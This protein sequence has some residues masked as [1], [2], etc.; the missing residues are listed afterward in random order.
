MIGETISHYRILSELGAGGMGIVYKAEDLKLRRPVALK[1]LPPEL[2]R[3]PEAKQRLVLE[4]QAASALDHPNVCTIHEIDETADG[5]L[6]MVMACY[7]GETLKQ[8]LIRGLLPADTAVQIATQVAD[9]LARA[10]AHSI[11][12]RDIKPANVFLDAYGQV[13]ILDFGLAML[14]GQTRLTRTGTTMGT[15][16]YMSPEQAR[17]EQADARSDV[18]AVGAVLHEM[19]TG[20]APFAGDHQQTVIFS[21]LN[22][23]P[24][25]V[26][27][28]R[29]DVPPALAAIVSGCLQKDPTK[30]YQNGGELL[31]ALRGLATTRSSLSFGPAGRRRSRRA[32]RIWLGLAGLTV[33]LITAFFVLRPRLV[34]PADEAIDSLAVLPLDNLSGD[35]AQEYFADGMTEA[36]IAELARIGALRVI[37][38]TSVMRFKDTDLPLPSIAA[39]LDVDAIVEGSVLR[40]GNRVRITAQLIRA[41]D[42]RHLWAESYER[43]LEDIL[44][45][46]QQIARLIA[47]AVDV[48]LTPG[49]EAALSA[50]VTVDPAAHEAYLKGRQLWN[51]RTPESLLRS[52]EYFQR[53]IDLDPGFAQAYAG[54]A[55][56]YIVFPSW[57]FRPAE[58]DYRSAETMARRALQIDG[59]LAEAYAVLAWVSLHLDRDWQQ[60]GRLYRQALATNPGSATT[61]QWY[62]SFLAEQERFEE[63][64]AEAQQACHLDPLSYI[65]SANLAQVLYFA[66]SYD[67]ALVWCGRAQEIDNRHP[68]ADIL[69]GYCYRDQARYDESIAAFITALEKVG[70][71]QTAI[72]DARRAYQDGQSE[73]YLRWLLKE[74]IL[75]FGQPYNAAYLRA[76]VNAWLGDR[77]AAFREL[78]KAFADRCDLLSQLG[79][80]PGFASLRGDPRFEQMLKRVGLR[81]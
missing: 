69:R 63:A 51:Q 25:S 43:N 54:L 11:V 14:A 41:R 71:P 75:Y 28:L 16:A 46:Q 19:L 37:S 49:E 76:E 7:E 40:A 20:K 35:P 62:A 53:A 52:L 4:A 60:A 64:L 48:K 13:R 31:A 42:D 33:V 26:S 6:F 10:H 57:G 2:T 5:R 70:A 68:Y 55:S 29:P 61:R 56:T 74:G 23:E 21:I 39:E 50:T 18:W 77:E 44:T 65:I 66:G 8:R 34:P 1:F 45:L 73:G 32:A 80:E 22:Q 81:E 78:E 38:R 3:D 24:E 58:P 59:S 30:R 9:G 17:G 79:V 47:G 67:E 15:V 27:A 36:L 72:A 12:H